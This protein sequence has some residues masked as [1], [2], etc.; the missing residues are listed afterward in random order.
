ME[1]QILQILLFVQ[2]L[3]LKKTYLQINVPQYFR[4]LTTFRTLLP[5]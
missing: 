5:G 3:I 4:F 1:T 2:T